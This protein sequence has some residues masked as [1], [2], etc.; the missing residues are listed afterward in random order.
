MKEKLKAFL[1]K[2]K[3]KK[4]LA[5]A[6]DIFFIVLLLLLLIPVTRRE[7]KTFVSKITMTQPR[8]NS[9]SDIFL[10]NDELSFTFLNENGEEKK[11]SDLGDSIIFLNFWATWCP[12]CRA[13][14]PSIQNLY[15]EYQ[16]KIVFA[17]ISNERPSDIN[18]YFN[19]NN[20]NLPVSSPLSAPKGRLS[21]STIPSTFIIGK[22]GELL[23][24]KK[25]AAKWDGESIK[26]SIDKHLNN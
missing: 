8:I 23:L 22:K 11:L 26:N 14:M 24:A 19:T 16:G 2:Q 1:E 3:N 21:S 25:G 12:P 10:N 4:P 7:I 20:Y 17:L 15:N 5:L 18:K 13:E 9:N 6:S